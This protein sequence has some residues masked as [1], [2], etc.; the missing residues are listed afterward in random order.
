MHI[1]GT[2]IWVALFNVFFTTTVAT[3]ATVVNTSCPLVRY[4]GR[5]K[6]PNDFGAWSFC[7]IRNGSIIFS[8]GIGNDAT[9]DAVMV[10]QHHARV[11]CFDPSISQ[12]LFEQLIAGERG[13]AFRGGP[14]LSMEERAF[15]RF[16]PFGL[17]A[18]DDVVEMWRDPNYKV[19][20]YPFRL[21]GSKAEPDLRVPLL[22][23]QTL[24][25]IAGVS[26]I[27]VLKVDIESGEYGLFSDFNSSRHWLGDERV[28][29][30]QINVEFH[31][32]KSRTHSS[33][34][35]RAAYDKL[36]L[37][38][39]L[40]IVKDPLGMESAIQREVELHSLLTC[41]YVPRYRH[42]DDSWLFIKVGPP[43]GACAQ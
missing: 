23:L 40:P 11:F 9:F 15:I 29:P 33:H 34:A 39:S 3:A 28:A 14:P 31:N 18:T 17:A 38:Q 42:T 1:A 2:A 7:P 30:S 26:R 21:P 35:M 16:F 20:A 4:G 19:M 10:R 27:D 24:M 22:R 5:Y 37:S 8:V 32:N 41:G 13:A 36:T 43:R 25:H 6:P 12:T